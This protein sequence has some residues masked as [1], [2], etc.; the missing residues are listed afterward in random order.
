[1]HS[2]HSAVEMFLLTISCPVSEVVDSSLMKFSSQSLNALALE[3]CQAIKKKPIQKYK[4]EEKLIH[5][6]LTLLHTFVLMQFLG[7]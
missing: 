7:F 1:M 2:T 5:D 4:H 3:I 6:V